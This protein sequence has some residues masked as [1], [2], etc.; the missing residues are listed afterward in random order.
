ML[1]KGR[2]GQATAELA[3][4]GSL[5]ILV[6]GVLLSYTRTIRE[7]QKIEQ[8]VFRQAL[9]DAHNYNFTVEDVAGQIRTDSGATISYSKTQDKQAGVI[10]EPNRRS[11]TAD[12]S[13]FW[14]NAEDPPELNKMDVNND[15]VSLPGKKI[16]YDRCSQTANYDYNL[17][18]EGF[19][20]PDKEMELN[21]WDAIAT[22]APVL[23]SGLSLKIGGETVADFLGISAGWVS[24]IQ[25]GVRTAQFYYFL[26]KYT[27]V[28]DDLTDS[29]NRRE[30]L[31]EQDEQMSKWGWRV[32]TEI[33]DSA[34]GIEPGQY[35][36]KEID[37]QTYDTL[38]DSSTQNNYIEMKVETPSQIINKREASLT[39]TVNRN[40]K[41]RYDVTAPDP[42]IPILDPAQKDLIALTP[43]QHAYEY[44]LSDIPL[45]QGLGADRSYA[46]SQVGTTVSQEVL[47]TT[48]H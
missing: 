21:T 7:Q 41:L 27:E 16:T 35:Y 37:A 12:Y 17:C 25:F 40:F 14:S 11:Y 42:V 23:A 28:M 4:F 3:V 8:Q 5:I 46:S 20:T 38:Q 31:E 24:A 13:V 32:A 18:K 33:K 15:A 39:D 9:N 6:A 2:R 34:D 36:V 1:I 26:D 47:W 10:F 22:I 19:E 29:D 43:S 30:E 45:S 48:P 44:S